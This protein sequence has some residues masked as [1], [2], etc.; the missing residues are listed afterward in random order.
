MIS[1][2]SMPCN[3]L[4]EVSTQLRNTNGSIL[5]LIIAGATGIFG[6]LRDQFVVKENEVASASRKTKKRS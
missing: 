3:V 1:S 6:S 5:A 4:R 2:H